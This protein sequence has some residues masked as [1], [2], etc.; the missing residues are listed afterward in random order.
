MVTLPNR[1]CVIGSSAAGKS[2]FARAI[3]RKMEGD[4]IELDSHF[5]GPKWKPTP[6]D[7]FIQSVRARLEANERWVVDGNYNNR[8]RQFEDADLIIWLD[9]P[10]RI[11]LTR[12]LRRTL[13]RLITKEELWNGN[14]ESWR[15]AFSHESIILWVFQTYWKR[16]REL[17]FE[18]SAYPPSKCIRFSHP[19]EAER[20]LNS[21]SIANNEV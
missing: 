2:T 4:Y 17:P 15:M 3:A 6:D 21:R 8:A 7:I 13:K 16:R 19:R 20:W 9:Y 11:V 18:L 5:H 1:I 10:F 12:V 14:R